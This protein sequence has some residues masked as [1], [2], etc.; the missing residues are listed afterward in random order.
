MPVAK[1]RALTV[2]LLAS[3]NGALYGVEDDVGSL[4]FVV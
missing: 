1:A 2:A 3:V 4:P